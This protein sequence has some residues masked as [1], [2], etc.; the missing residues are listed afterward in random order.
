MDELVAVC[1]RLVAVLH[2]EM[3]PAIIES[4]FTN[5]PVC[6]AYLGPLFCILDEEGLSDR[7]G[8]PEVASTAVEMIAAADP[9]H[10]FVLGGRS[11]PG[12]HIHRRLDPISECLETADEGH[13][14]RLEVYGCI[15]LVIFRLGEIFT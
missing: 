7:E 6:L 5:T 9:A 2:P 14:P 10:H 15:S 12:Y 8:E 4:R 3:N 1:L 13:R 11:I